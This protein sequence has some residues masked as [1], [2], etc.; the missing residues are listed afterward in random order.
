MTLTVTERVCPSLVVTH[1]PDRVWLTHTL[2]DQPQGEDGGER[3]D[4]HEPAKSRLLT[5]TLSLSHLYEGK[6]VSELGRH[7]TAST[8]L[9]HTCTH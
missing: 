6:G 7:L 4:D 8:S 3:N 9:T 1:V 5:L 2:T